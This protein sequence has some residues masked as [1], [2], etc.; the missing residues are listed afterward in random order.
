MA[1]E[2]ALENLCSDLRKLR[3][4]IAGVERTVTQ[5]RPEMEAVI[6]VDEVSDDVTELESF[7]R[8]CLD[9]AEAALRSVDPAFDAARLRRSL[10][11]AELRFHAI[12]HLLV[13]DLLTYE[14]VGALVGFGRKYGHEW[15]AWVHAV[16]LGLEK[17]RA[18]LHGIWGAFLACWE[19]I[20]ERLLTGPIA[21]HT[22]NIGQQISSR[23]LDDRTLETGMT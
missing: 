5:D 10:A 22:T 23:A 14:K 9:A 20:A 8:E 18:A 12:A 7:C 13:S 6:L 2:A 3:D 4:A 21:L 17:C 11:S 1:L 16:R 19:E 15:A